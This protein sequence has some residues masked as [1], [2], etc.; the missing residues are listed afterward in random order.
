MLIR[1]QGRGIVV[2]S[3]NANVFT[4]RA[5]KEI[6]ETTAAA[7]ARLFKCDPQ[8]VFVSS[9]GVI[10]EQP[11]AEKIVAAIARSRPTPG[12]QC[13]G[14]GGAGDHDHRHLPKGCHSRCDDRWRPSPAQ[15]LC[16]RLW[17]D[18]ARHG[19]NAR[20]CLHRRRFARGGICSR[21][22][23]TPTD[24]SFNS[25]TVD[26]DTSTSDTVLL[27]CDPDR[28]RIARSQA[29]RPAAWRFSP[30]ARRGHDRSCPAD[31]A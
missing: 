4:G 31:R 23:P 16:K 19:D 2:N 27:S 5:G 17:Y 28:P 30:G 12:G 26:G 18:R 13:L 7:A 9:T 8:Q 10:G 21:C 1:R 25:I 11:P 22:S 6:V 20:L 24:N 14:A 3:G 29:R 15:W